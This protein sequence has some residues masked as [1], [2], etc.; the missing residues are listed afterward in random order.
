MLDATTPEG[1]GTDLHAWRFHK[2]RKDAT[3]RQQKNQC[4][5][6][7]PVTSA[8]VHSRG[9]H[10]YTAEEFCRE[11]WP[12]MFCC[13]TKHKEG[14]NASPAGNRT[15]GLVRYPVILTTILPSLIHMVARHK[16]TRQVVPKSTR[17]TKTTKTTSSTRHHN[18]SLYKRTPVI[19][20]DTFLNAT[21]IIANE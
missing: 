6:G 11:E 17:D 5:S 4:L 9:P 8:G 21:A 15:P 14:Q 12:G 3:G 10:S 2:A 13:P 1:A 18:T 16:S 19:F 7:G 20:M